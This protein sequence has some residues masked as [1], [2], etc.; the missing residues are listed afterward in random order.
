MDDAQFGSAVRAVRI[1]RGLSQ[2]EVA[3]A[4]RVS[5]SVVSLI[6]RGGLEGTS[7]RLVRQVTV[8]LGVSLSLEPRW[9]GAE[10]AKLLDERHAALVRAVVARLIAEGW[11]ALPERT[12]SVW[13]ERGSIDVLAWQPASRAL[14]CVEAK[15]RLPDLQDLLSAMDRKRRLAPAAARPEGWKPLVVGSVLAVP[16]ETWARNAL[17]RFDAV[18]AAAQPAGTLDV[19]RWLAHPDREIRGVWFVPNDAPGSATRRPGGSMRIRP[20]RAVAAGPN[21]RSASESPGRKSTTQLA[22]SPVLPTQRFP[23]HR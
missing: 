6:E 3:E 16:E 21:P 2:S 4:A 19:R 5:R 1:R 12:F 8:A 17:K 10:M 7:L 20:R 15:T 23:G 22:D 13:G 14:L 9:R 18:F 11:Q